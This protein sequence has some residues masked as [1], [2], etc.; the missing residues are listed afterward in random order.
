MD[1]Q[2]EQGGDTPLWS[3]RRRGDGRNMLRPYGLAHTYPSQ[4][5]DGAR[6]RVG[7]RG[8]LYHQCRQ[9]ALHHGI[10]VMLNIS[11]GKA[12]HAITTL[13]A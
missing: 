12:Q 1:G 7:A 2:D 13:A 4:R 10:K 6:G 8:N 5:P 9:D 3:P 11:I